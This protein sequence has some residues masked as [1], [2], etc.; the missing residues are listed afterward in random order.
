MTNPGR[1]LWRALRGMILAVVCLTMS[2]TAHGAAGGAVHLS[3]GLLIGG[4]ALSVICVA[5]ADARRSFG[6]IVAVVLTSQ[7]VLHLFAGAGDH[8]A[9]PAGFGLTSEMVAYHAIVAV[10]ASALLAY[11]ERLVWALWGLARLPATP[12]LGTL[13][14]GGASPA[15]PRAYEPVRPVAQELR[16]GGLTSRAPPVLI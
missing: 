4:L 16:L 13:V 6:G 1:G 9:E 14:P 15:I 3:P 11:G 7:V 10:T 2:M 8:V 5:A 12:V